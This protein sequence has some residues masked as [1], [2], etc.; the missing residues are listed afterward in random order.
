MLEGKNY[1]EVKNTPFVTP[2]IKCNTEHEKTAAVTR[3][4][5]QYSEITA[6]VTGDMKHLT[7]SKEELSGL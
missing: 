3:V 5:T 7:W 1:R 6:V 2:F 4:H